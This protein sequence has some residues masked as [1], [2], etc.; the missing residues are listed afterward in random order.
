MSEEQLIHHPSL[1]SFWTES[2]KDMEGEEVYALYS[3]RQLC[4]YE[5][6]VQQMYSHMI[7]R[8]SKYP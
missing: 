1:F 3:N 4:K 5:E 8:Q 7:A 2:K 6:K